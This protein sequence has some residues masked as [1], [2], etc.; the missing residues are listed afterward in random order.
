[1]DDRSVNILDKGYVRLVDWMGDDIKVVNAARVSFD[2]ESDFEEDGSLPNRDW[3]LIR[4]LWRHGHTSPFRQCTIQYEVRAPLMVA[5]QAFK[6]VVGSSHQDSFLGWNEASKRYITDPNE[7]YLPNDTQWRSVPEN[8]KQGSGPPVNHQI[9]RKWTERIGDLQKQGE[10]Y[11]QEML[12]D[13]ICPEQARLAL[14]A[15]GVYIRWRWTISLQGVLH[16]LDQRTADDA[17]SE[18]RA[19]ADAVL[20]LTEPLFPASFAAWRE[21]SQ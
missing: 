4:F 5:R 11:F 1:M 3:K 20:Q 7:F 17:Q 9:G 12:D 15:Y 8:K 18:I 6:Y 14:P 13:G 2:K 19:M 21:T 16:F 10:R